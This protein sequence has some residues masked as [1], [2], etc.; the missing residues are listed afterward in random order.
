MSTQTPPTT[1]WPADRLRAIA[2]ADDLHIAPFREDSETP[3]TPTWIWNVAVDG[4]LFVR[5]YHG[6][7]SRWH[8]AATRERA[9]QIT[10]AGRTD[11]VAFEPVSDAT[12]N[13]QIDEAYRA[14]HS[15]SPYLGAMI[16]DRARG[17]TVRVSPRAGG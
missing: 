6:T 11:D 4:D 16:S 17:A 1:A 5:A 14:K 10:A 2:E 15:G 13:D 8:R 3:G 9:G 12:L 7:A